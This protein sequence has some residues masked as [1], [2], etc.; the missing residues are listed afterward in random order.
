M[1]AT[2]SLATTIILTLMPR[3]LWDFPDAVKIDI[4]ERLS[5]AHVNFMPSCPE[6]IC[7]SYLW[8]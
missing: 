8:R 6:A 7:P 3:F 5:V 1:V 4:G 2:K